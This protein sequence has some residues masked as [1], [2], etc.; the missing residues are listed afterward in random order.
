VR[1]IIDFLSPRGFPEV[2]K[3]PFWPSQSK[4]YLPREHQ[5]MVFYP[6]PEASDNIY[7]YPPIHVKTQNTFWLP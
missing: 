6:E 3:V 5:R 1:A 7:Q 4:F 2:L